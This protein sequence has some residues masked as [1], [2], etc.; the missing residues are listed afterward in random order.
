MSSW[1]RLKSVVWFLWYRGNLQRLSKLWKLREP[2]QLT[3]ILFTTI[4]TIT[5]MEI[6]VLEIFR[7]AQQFNFLEELELLRKSKM[8]CK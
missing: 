1:Y 3:L 8:L 2:I 5:E 4:I 6:V 7:N